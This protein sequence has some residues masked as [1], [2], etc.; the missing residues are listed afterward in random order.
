MQ[1]G[2]RALVILLAGILSVGILAGTGDVSAEKA[3]DKGDVKLS[4]YA[5]W[6]RPGVL[7]VDGQRVVV[8]AVDEMEG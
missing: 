1:D 2:D 6:K 4:S 8:D 7:I 3:A 5:E